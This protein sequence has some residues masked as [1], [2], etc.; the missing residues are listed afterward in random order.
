MTKRTREE[1]ERT[2][3]DE[4]TVNFGQGFSNGAIPY[5]LECD[6]TTYED[7]EMGTR[8]FQREVWP[9]AVQK[10]RADEGPAARVGRRNGSGLVLVDTKP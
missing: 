6:L 7:T 8:F 1:R 2:N 10:L 4:I 5:I 9:R 3:Q